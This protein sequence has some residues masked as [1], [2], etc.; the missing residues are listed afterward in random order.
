MVARHPE[1]QIRRVFCL[2]LTLVPLLYVVMACIAPSGLDSRD[3]FHFTTEPRCHSAEDFGEDFPFERSPSCVLEVGEVLHLDA[4]AVKGCFVG[5]GCVSALRWGC[6][7]S[8]VSSDPSV[9]T[10]SPV[11]LARGISAGVVTII[12]TGDCGSLGVRSAS[13][14]L[15]I[16]PSTST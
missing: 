10:V 12:A 16:V 6:T 4:D 15:E 2:K 8:W 3:V 9:A 7:V 13:A 14:E 11:G 1:P 5:L